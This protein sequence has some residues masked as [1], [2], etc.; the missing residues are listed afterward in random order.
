MPQKARIIGTV[1]ATG[2]TLSVSRFTTAEDKT[3]IPIWPYGVIGYSFTQYNAT[4]TFWLDVR[5]NVM[6]SSQVISGLSGIIGLSAGIMPV[7]SAAGTTQFNWNGIPRPVDIVLQGTST[8]A[9][10]TGSVVI[11]CAVYSP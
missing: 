6:G 11:T 3:H 1:T 10:L 7:R 9:A 2:A 4:Q 5:S 8:G